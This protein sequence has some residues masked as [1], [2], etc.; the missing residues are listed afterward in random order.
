MAQIWMQIPVKL[1]QFSLTVNNKG[2]IYCNPIRDS[3]RSCVSLNFIPARPFSYMRWPGTSN[4]L[5]SNYGWE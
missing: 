4:Y 5:T 1:A 3:V 2:I